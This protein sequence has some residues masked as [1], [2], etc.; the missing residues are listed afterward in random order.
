MRERVRYICSLYVC[1]AD[2][3][4]CAVWGMNRLRL[5]EHC[6]RGFESHSRHECLCAFILCLCCFVCR[7]RACDGLIPRPRVL[8]TVYRIQKLKKRPRSTRL[9]AVGIFT[10]VSSCS[11]VSCKMIIWLRV[12]TS[13]K[14]PW[15]VDGFPVEKYP[16]RSYWPVPHGLLTLNP[17][18]L[19]GGCWLALL[20]SDW[21]KDGEG[22]CLSVTVY[23]RQPSNVICSLPHTDISR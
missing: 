7:Q 19:G 17:F 21:L 22:I 8:S 1:W 18:R 14:M 15:S 13:W 2:H 12:R 23:Q 20:V 10:A 3:S 11:A 6:D 9:R 5:L 16:D 4:G